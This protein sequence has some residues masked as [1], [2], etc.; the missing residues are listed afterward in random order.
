MFRNTVLS[1]RK[2]NDFHLHFTLQRHIVYDFRQ[3]DTKKD[4]TQNLNIHT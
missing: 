4:H 2:M 3:K 1:N